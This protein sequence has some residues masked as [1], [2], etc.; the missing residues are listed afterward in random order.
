M[1]VNSDDTRASVT[2]CDFSSDQKAVITATFGGRVVVLD[3][4]TQQVNVDYDI[5]M[6]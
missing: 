2:C 1:M 5:M 3:L 6:L 4:Q